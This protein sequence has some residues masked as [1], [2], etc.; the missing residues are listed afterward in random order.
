VGWY[1]LVQ[2]VMNT[3]NA[4]FLYPANDGQLKLNKYLGSIKCV[5]ILYV[6]SDYHSLRADCLL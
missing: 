1:K 2:A 4:I 5:I 6:M 3:I